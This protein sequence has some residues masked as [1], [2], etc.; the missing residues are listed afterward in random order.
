MFIKLNTLYEKL[1]HFNKKRHVLKE[2][3]VEENINSIINLNKQTRFINKSIDAL[4]LSN[5][6]HKDSNCWKNFNAVYTYLLDVEIEAMRCENFVRQS[7]FKRKY[8]IKYT[9]SCLSQIKKINVL[10]KKTNQK[11][12]IAGMREISN[13]SYL[14]E[15]IERNKSEAIK[16][17]ITIKNADI[18]KDREII[19]ETSSDA[20]S[21][22]CEG[23]ELTEQFN[24]RIIHL[25]ETIFHSIK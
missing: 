17:L 13:I 20:Y 1:T 16:N 10:L 6:N 9:K 11:L 18:K 22:L 7:Y 3:V 14:L 19:H 5:L 25:L 8:S 12:H 23:E 24:L 2:S 4:A 21:R 15:K